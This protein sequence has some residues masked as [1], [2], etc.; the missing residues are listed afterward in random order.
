MITWASLW[1]LPPLV[2]VLYYVAR[3]RSR[4]QRMQGASSPPGPKGWP[5]VGN[6]LELASSNAQT[7]TEIYRRWAEEYGSVVQFSLM[8]N[9]QVIVSDHNIANDLFVNRGSKYSDR[10]APH[11][12]E[13]I[14]M[15]QNPG[16]RPKDEGWRRQA[17][18]MHSAISITSINRY[19]SLMD[20]EATFTLGELI[21][22]PLS[23]NDQFLRY[24]YSVLTTSLLGFPVRSTSDP[25]MHHNEEF[26]AELMKAFRPDCFPSNVFPILRALPY[27]LVPSLRKMESLRREYEEQMW[28]FRSEVEGLVK[29]GAATESIYKH[30]LLNRGDYSVTDEESVHTFQALLD[31][32]TRSPHNNLL[33]FLFLMMDYPE[34]QRRLQQEVDSVCGEHRIPNYT[35]IPRL[36]TVRAVVKEGIRYRSIVAEMGIS[37][38]LQTDDHYNGFYFKKGTVFHVPFRSILMDKTEY[39]DGELFNP[40]RWLDPSYPTYREPLTVYP[41]CRKFAA[42]GYGRRACPG[43]EFSERT[44]VI[45]VAK[46]A[47]AVD[48]RW[49]LD[50]DGNALRQE[51]EYEPVPAPRPM[52]FRCGI[53]AR[54]LGRVEVIKGAAG[55]LHV[56]K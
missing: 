41:N 53:T 27:W 37:H 31:G 14:T 52:K 24:S 12:L 40:A 35:D 39:P 28:R 43:V 51:I 29:K 1:W 45:M 8:G 23:F 36:P 32:G 25:Y 42:F 50:R 4:K 17:K 55:G 10:G 30:F 47:W 33:T 7:M 9:K 19:Q 16:F 11:A 46:L 13:Y 54:N 26:T 21:Q 49:P 18:M 20:D 56:S 34:W 2:G 44:L 3:N 6:A 15:N 48:I 5:F 38:A 22:S